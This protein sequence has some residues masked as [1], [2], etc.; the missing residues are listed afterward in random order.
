MTLFYQ[1]Y[2]FAMGAV[3]GSFL[4]V[5]IL[6]WPRERSIV[7]PRSRCSS[8]GHQLEWFENI[9]VLSWV[10]LRARCRVCE[11]P[12]SVQYPLIELAVAIGWLLAVRTYGPSFTAIRV[13]LFGTILLG[14]AITD[15]REFLIPDGFTL[16]GLIIVLVTAAIGF[17]RGDAT[18]FASPY[19]AIIGA[20][21]GAGMIAII[22]WI[23]EIAMGKE[24]MGLGDVTLM[25]FVGAA[26]GPQRAIITVFLGAV[27]GMAAWFTIIA[28]LSWMRRTPAR[29]AQTELA[30]GSAAVAMPLVPFGVFLAP[31]AVINLLWGDSLMRMIV[32]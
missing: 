16:S 22:G 27:L 3:I 17:V 1:I 21:A 28:P 32:R 7:R 14:V 2:A 19:D 13:A 31:A 6:R 11:E 25:A 20:C 10:F 26:L 24:A 12:I 23:G 8:C 5:C 9:P 18:P 29:G 30:L 4:N 15:L